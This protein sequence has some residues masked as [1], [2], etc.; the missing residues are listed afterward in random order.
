MVEQ[1]KA[2]GGRPFVTD[3]NTLYSGSRH[4]AVDHL[5]TAVEH[6]FDYAVLGAPV[7]IAD[8]LD[9][10]NVLEVAIRGKHF[11]KV[12][13]AGDI[14]STRD[15]PAKTRELRLGDH[16]VVALRVGTDGRVKA[17]RVV[18]ASRDSMTL[19]VIVRATDA[20][21]AANWLRKA[22]LI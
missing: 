14:N 15:Y 4:N 8:G 12:K 3:T 6:G 13:I 21:D 18:R 22:G 2:R 20:G 19:T 11:E 17:C 5:L 7:I 16:V 10:T 9:S 1:V